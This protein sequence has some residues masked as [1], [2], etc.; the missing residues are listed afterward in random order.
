MAAEVEPNVVSA[1][2]Q[3]VGDDADLRERVLP[4]LGLI[5]LDLR[6]RPM[7][8]REGGL[9][10]TETASRKNAGAHYTPKSL[11]EEVVL[12]ALQP[13][14]YRPGPYQSADETEL[15]TQVFG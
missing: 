15:E 1:L 2:S 12:H 9:M 11:A 6:G 3:A 14:C 13:L 10:V 5:R 7:V 4:W 8:V